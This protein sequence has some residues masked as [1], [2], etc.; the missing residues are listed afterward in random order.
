MG[1]INLI[2]Y[3]L[4]K[5]KL[6]KSIIPDSEND[7]ETCKICLK[8]VIGTN[9]VHCYDCYS[10]I[11]E[12]VHNDTFTDE[13]FENT[14]EQLENYYETGMNCASY[15]LNTMNRYKP[16]FA[17]IKDEKRLNEVKYCLNELTQY[18]EDYNSLHHTRTEWELVLKKER[19]KKRK[20]EAG[21]DFE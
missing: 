6:L 21:K 17:S 11:Q 2:K 1:I 14:Y 3:K 16:I 19:I 10:D 20:R 12:S 9:W 8:R 7:I 4:A 5:R 18:V 13:N 15:L